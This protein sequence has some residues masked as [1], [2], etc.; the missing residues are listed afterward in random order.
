MS[1]RS[2]SLQS[3]SH[4]PSTT[5]SSE[6]IIMPDLDESFVGSIDQGTTSTRFLIF[7]GD[8]EL[9]VSHQVEIEQIYPKP[10]YS[11]LYPSFMPALDANCT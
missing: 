2:S 8:G 11:N 4:N 9:V 1:A 7:K 5:N 3:L 6:V 10:G